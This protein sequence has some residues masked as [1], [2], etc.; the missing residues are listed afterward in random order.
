MYAHDLNHAL[1]LISYTWLDKA[2][3]E[4]PSSNLLLQVLNHFLLP[5][6]INSTLFCTFHIERAHARDRTVKRLGVYCCIGISSQKQA[7]G[8][9]EGERLPSTDDRGWLLLLSTADL[10]NVYKRN[11]PHIFDSFLIRDL[12][13]RSIVY[14]RVESLVDET[15]DTN[16]ARTVV[17]AREI[18]TECAF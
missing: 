11:M 7:Q 9:N 14:S 18:L 16:H 5:L 3:L 8:R 2:L 15:K 17:E 6:G 1:P 13:V 4:F 10:Q 12:T